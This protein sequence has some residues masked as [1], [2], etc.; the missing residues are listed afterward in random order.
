VFTA[1]YALSPCIKQISF[2][3]KGLNRVQINENSNQPY[4]LP[5]NTFLASTYAHTSSVTWKSFSR[6]SVH[7][8]GSNY[9]IL[10]LAQ[11]H[12]ILFTCLDC[13]T[14]SLNWNLSFLLLLCWL[15]HEV[16]WTNGKNIQSGFMT[17]R[18]VRLWLSLPT[19]CEKNRRNRTHTATAEVRF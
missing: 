1:R 14:N 7:K 13:V 18:L 4:L 17:C 9:E 6:L 5:L 11:A 2:V 16:E 10:I 8:S 15:W 19:L 3:L 12:C